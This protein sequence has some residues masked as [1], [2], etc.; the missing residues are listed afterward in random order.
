MDG[1]ELFAIWAPSE[2]I[3]SPWAKPVVFT[4]GARNVTPLPE[5]DIRF[6]NGVTRDTALIVDLNG[7]QSVAV[8]VE[9]ALRGWRPVPLYNAIDADQPVISVQPVRDALEAGASDVQRAYLAPNAPPAFLVDSRRLDSGPVAPGKFDNRW[10]VFPQDFPSATL[11]KA[12][13]I[14]RALIVYDRPY[15][16]FDVIKV[17]GIWKRGGLTMLKHPLTGHIDESDLTAGREAPEIAPVS[18][19][20][21]LRSSFIVTA[22]MSRGLR[23]NAAG[24]FGSRVPEPARYG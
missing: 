17:A 18:R 10:V 1:K 15:P 16:D 8:G 9:L 19:F 23:R 13:G 21:F 20:D 24:G 4:M 7:V 3:W 14:T 6:L 2:S 12:N 11:L 5:V 22:L